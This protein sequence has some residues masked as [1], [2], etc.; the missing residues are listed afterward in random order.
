MNEEKLAQLKNRYTKF[1]LR[2][3][4][5]M[6]EEEISEMRLIAKEIMEMYNEVPSM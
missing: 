2:D 1:C 3:I 6:S 4:K 5:T